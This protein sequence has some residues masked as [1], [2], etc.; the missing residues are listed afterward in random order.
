MKVSWLM[1]L[2]EGRVEREKRAADRSR[3]SRNRSG[4]LNDFFWKRRARRSRGA[5]S[6]ASI[7]K[8]MSS[9][10]PSNIPMTTIKAMP[11]SGRN[12]TKLLSE[13]LMLSP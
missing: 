8:E 4:V 7:V 2:G 1:S 12:K 11:M 9:L 3:M 10:A 5:K 13:E 6:V